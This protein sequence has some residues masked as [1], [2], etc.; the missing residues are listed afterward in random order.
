[1][2]PKPTESKHSSQI[3]YISIGVIVC[4]MVAVVLLDFKTLS[5]QLKMTKRNLTKNP[6]V[7]TGVME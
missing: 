2:A 5:F 4:M 3:G 7:A 1:M 6:I